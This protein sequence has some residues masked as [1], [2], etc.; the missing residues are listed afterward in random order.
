[1]Y[2]VLLFFKIILLNIILKLSHTLAKKY[3]N[4][5]SLKKAILLTEFP[6]NWVHYV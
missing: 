4:Y 3:A 1:M 2:S 6:K 5:I